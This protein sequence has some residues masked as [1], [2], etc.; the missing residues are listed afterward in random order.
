MILGHG[1]RIVGD[2]IGAHRRAL[3]D[4]LHMRKGPHTAGGIC[5]VE[6]PHVDGRIEWL[7]LH[8]ALEGGVVPPITLH[9]A[10]PLGDLPAL[11]AIETGD[12]VALLEQGPH[13]ARADMAG[14]TDDADFQCAT[15]RTAA[16]S[17]KSYWKSADPAH[18]IPSLG[19]TSVTPWA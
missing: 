11:S 5:T 10:G 2:P 7:P 17:C 18:S 1:H 3:D 8:G 15:K 12:L 16:S 14:A 19:P 13:E 4:M 9:P 6:T